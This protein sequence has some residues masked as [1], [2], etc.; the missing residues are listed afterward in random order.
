MTSQRLAAVGSHFNQRTR[1]NTRLLVRETPR[2]NP[3]SEAGKVVSGF[4]AIRRPYFVTD[5]V[6]F[7]ERYDRD[8]RRPRTHP[9]PRL[10]S[11]HRLPDRDDIDDE[12]VSTVYA[13]TDRPSCEGTTRNSAITSSKRKH[14][15]HKFLEARRA[16]ILAR[17]GQFSNVFA[18][19]FARSND[20]SVETRRWV[21][22]LKRA[23]LSG[24][25]GNYAVCVPA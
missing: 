1:S 4:H 2:L 10:F 11:I 23:S 15:G 3:A 6:A 14:R 12:R 24:R 21:H 7:D 5:T 9:S 13:R 22:S 17:H 8:G 16:A 19:F 18:R 20:D 25:N